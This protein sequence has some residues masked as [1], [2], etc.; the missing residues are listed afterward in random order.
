MKRFHVQVSVQ[1]LEP[2]LKFYAN[3]FGVAPTVQHFDYAKWM[4][5]DPRVNFA[6]SSR[7]A[8]AGVNHLGLQVESAEELSVLRGQLQAADAGLLEQS[9]QACCQRAVPLHGQLRS[10]HLW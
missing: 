5:E 3:L 1:E 2:A 6:I 10:Q 4:L 8:P 7:G 9:Q